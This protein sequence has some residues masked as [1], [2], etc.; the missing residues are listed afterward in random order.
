MN[1]SMPKPQPLNQPLFVPQSSGSHMHL[2]HENANSPYQP[3]A[4][5]LSHMKN[6]REVQAALDLTHQII[7][8]LRRDTPTIRCFSPQMSPAL[9]QS[10]ITDQLQQHP[11]GAII[12]FN[13]WATHAVADAYEKN[14]YGASF[15]FTNMHDT[16]SLTALD[17]EH[18]AHK[19]L[20]GISVK[21]PSYA[22]L[23]SS[24]HD[25]HPRAK[26]VHIICDVWQ[27]LKT[28]NI[29]QYGI[30]REN[31][32]LCQSRGI[33]VE[34][35]YIRSDIDLETKLKTRLK[36]N[37]VI[38]TGDNSLALAH[39]DLI[40]LYA[41]LHGIPVVTQSLEMV[42]AGHAALGCGIWGEYGN[43]ILAQSVINTVVNGC[44]PSDIPL[45]SIVAKDQVRCARDEVMERQGLVLSP[46]EKRALGAR[47]IDDGDR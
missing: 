12:T 16:S 25:W 36:S 26:R 39:G 8:E 34:P 18:P 47:Y 37:D 40:A 10:N 3:I 27:N 17:Q 20:A 24:L 45:T 43:Q 35:L 23:L 4:L 9:M 14:H 13:D 15:L 7:G 42:K 38:F 5:V 22:K 28:N 29:M 21:H 6:S 32:A 44:S 2:L 1:V 41:E 30:T 33:A 19:H 11:Y 46:R 31:I